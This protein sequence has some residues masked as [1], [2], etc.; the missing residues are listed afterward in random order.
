VASAIP[1]RSWKAIWIH[2]AA[3]IPAMLLAAELFQ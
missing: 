2:F 3:P 1:A